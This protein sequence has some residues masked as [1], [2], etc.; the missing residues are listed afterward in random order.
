MSAEYIGSRK[1]IVATTVEGLRDQLNAALSGYGAGA[2]TQVGMRFDLRS[3]VP[4]TPPEDQ[5]SPNVV[6]A[7][8]G[9]GVYRLYWWTGAAWTTPYI[10]GDSPRFTNLTVTGTLGVTGA[11]TLGALT[12]GGHLLFNPDSTYDIGASGATRPRNIYVASNA[13]VGGTLGVTGA[14]TLST[15]TVTSTSSFEASLSM[16]VSGEVRGLLSS[17]TNIGNTEAGLVLRGEASKGIAFGSNQ[18]TR[19]FLTSTG[20]LLAFADNTFD[21][22]ADGANRPHD[23]FVGNAVRSGAFD[24]NKNGGGGLRAI[25][26]SFAGSQHHVTVGNDASNQN[27]V[28]FTSGS[29]AARFNSSGNFAL[30]S[31][32][33]VTIGGNHVVGARGAAVADASATVASVQAQL[34][35]LLARIRAHGLIAP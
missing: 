32:N 20:D 26:Y 28:F 34:N 17:T 5:G 15:L 14:S 1:R 13:V 9:S 6:M 3:E 11:S 4:T 16:G 30:A 18:T 23:L 35:L 22:G 25:G 31:G 21:V 2:A 24:L 29:E 7:D 10:S 8:S 27:V 19:W 33:V 12:V